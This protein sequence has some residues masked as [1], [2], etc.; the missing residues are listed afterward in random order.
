MCA[1][2]RFPMGMEL[3]RN[4]RFSVHAEIAVFYQILPPYQF[5]PYVVDQ[6]AGIIIQ[7]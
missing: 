1:A 6:N 2:I 3:Y 7:F 5:I 4:E